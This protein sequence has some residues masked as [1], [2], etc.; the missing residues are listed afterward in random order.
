MMK[1]FKN[2]RRKCN[3]FNMI[4]NIYENPTASI[5]FNGEGPNAFSLRSGI[6]KGCLLSPL[7]V[8]L[9]KAIKQ[10]KKC[11]P[12]WKEKIKLP[13]FA[14]DMTLHIENSK[15]LNKKLLEQ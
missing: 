8:I 1:V 12:E 2:L 14:Y 11:H 3:F 7:L 5:V 4:K 15:E 13:L 10:E 9:A 6:R